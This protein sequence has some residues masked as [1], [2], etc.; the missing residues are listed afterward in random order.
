[1][2][3]LNLCSQY[4]SNHKYD[5][6]KLTEARRNPDVNTINRRKDGLDAVLQYLGH[7]HAYLSMGSVPKL[8]IKPMFGHT[9][10]L[11]IYAYPLHAQDVI[12]TSETRDWLACH[13]EA[14]TAS[15]TSS[16]LMFPMSACSPSI[17]TQP[18]SKNSFA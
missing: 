12:D 13:S 17:P 2:R 10:P 16:S 18:A 1:M 9:T 5:M 3:G 6:R 11:G 7:E 14:M 4:F 8:G 15:P